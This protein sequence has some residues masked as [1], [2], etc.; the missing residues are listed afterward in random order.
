MPNQSLYSPKGSLKELLRLR[1]AEKPHKT[2]NFLHTVYSYSAQEEKHYMHKPKWNT[3]TIK[4]NKSQLLKHIK[5]TAIFVAT[6][7]HRMP[8]VASG[9]C[10]RHK[11]VSERFA[12]PLITVKWCIF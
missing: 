8:F 2:L 6:Y 11:Y 7:I 5:T 4:P 3:T 10:E 9:T 12:L 1:K